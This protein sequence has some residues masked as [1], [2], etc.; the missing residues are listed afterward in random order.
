MGSVYLNIDKQSVKSKVYKFIKL[1]FLFNN[2]KISMPSKV[3]YAFHVLKNI[4]FKMY[5][6]VPLRL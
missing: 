1:H 3:L 2:H 6:V 5:S 4:I